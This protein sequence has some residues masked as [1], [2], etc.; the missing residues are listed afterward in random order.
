MSEIKH[1]GITQA[2]ETGAVREERKG[3]G[4]CDLLPACALLRLARHYENGVEHYG[5]RN[6]EKGIPIS[7]MLD[8]GI[9]H[10]LKY[11]DGQKDE[12]HLAAAAWNILGAMW[13]EEK[14]PELQD[15]PSRLEDDMPPKEAFDMVREDSN[16]IRDVDNNIMAVTAD[17]IRWRISISG[18]IAGKEAQ[19]YGCERI[20]L[21]KRASD[22][23][24]Q[25]LSCPKSYTK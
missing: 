11:L 21:C 13:M 17:Q 6:W 20:D 1:T 15:I 12:D 25:S 16:L 5:D 8:S 19:C 4:R 9:R 7:V 2:Y 14:M 23:T 24:H 18:F 3:K 22:E 10:L